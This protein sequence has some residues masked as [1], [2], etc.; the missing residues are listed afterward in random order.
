MGLIIGTSFQNTHSYSLFVGV[1][2]KQRLLS[3]WGA[4]FHLASTTTS[5]LCKKL[6]VCEL[7]SAILV[8][9]ASASDLQVWWLAATFG[10]N[11]LYIRAHQNLKDK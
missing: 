11:M 7:A 8:R 10:A 6:Q 3:L 9:A 2:S 1:S 5:R 4:A